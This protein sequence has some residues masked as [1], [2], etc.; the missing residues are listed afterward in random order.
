M[1]GNDMNDDDNVIRSAMARGEW[2]SASPDLK[3]RIMAALDEPALGSATVPAYMVRGN[4]MPRVGGWLGALMLVVFCCGILTGL[5]T[6][7]ATETQTDPL[8]T[9]SGTVMMA[10][11][12]E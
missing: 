10:Q 6:G 5:D 2:P 11:L 1:Q 7:Q 4:N 3:A 12:L 8:Y 9:D